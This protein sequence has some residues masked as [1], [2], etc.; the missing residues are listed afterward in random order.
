MNNILQNYIETKIKKPLIA[1][2]ATDNNI[3][4]RELNT[5]Y[6]KLIKIPLEKTV[7]A[8]FKKEK[9]LQYQKKMSGMEMTQK[10]K[11]EWDNLSEDEKISFERYKFEKIYNKVI[12]QPLPSRY[13]HFM[14]KKP[15]Q[16]KNMVLSEMED[17]K[18][19]IDISSWTVEELS[20]WLVDN[21]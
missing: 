4:E 2:I 13:D 21:T 1:K 9:I 3:D 5:I 6:S 12:P 16:L 11:E 18:I 19:N 8:L 15:K 17:Q 10:I 7:Y 20:K 14:K